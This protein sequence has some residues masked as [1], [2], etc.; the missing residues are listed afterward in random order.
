MIDEPLDL[1][2]SNPDLKSNTSLATSVALPS[3][4]KPISGP[5]ARYGLASLHK[6]PLSPQDVRVG[7]G[8]RGNIVITW[9]PVRYVD[10]TGKYP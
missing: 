8:Q 6:G 5:F 2:H 1:K 3:S 7:K 9:T 4:M 10:R